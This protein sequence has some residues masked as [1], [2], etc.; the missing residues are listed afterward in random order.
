[1][2]DSS[3]NSVTSRGYITFSVNL[4]SGL[5]SGAV[6]NNTGYVYFDYNPAVVT[7]T[8]T[9]TIVTPLGLAPIKT[10]NDIT[11]TASPNPFNEI[12]NIEV[13]GIT[14][15]YNF[16][17]YDVTGRLLLSIPSNDSNHFR[18]ARG[19]LA[20]EVYLYRLRV[21]NNGVG[22]YGKIVVQ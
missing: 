6:I 17:L 16:E 13:T 3:T 5:N 4:K 19:N 1:L 10:K 14:G 9:D 22:A 7:N 2:P 8:V 12:T 20:A 11:V 15:S 18:I 21:G